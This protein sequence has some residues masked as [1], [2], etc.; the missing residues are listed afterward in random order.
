LDDCSC[1]PVRTPQCS[2][3]RHIK[4]PN[5]ERKPNEPRQLAGVKANRPF[6]PLAKVTHFDITLH[7]EVRKLPSLPVVARTESR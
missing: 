4:F 3:Y 1:F 2:I 5:R 6:H 7:G